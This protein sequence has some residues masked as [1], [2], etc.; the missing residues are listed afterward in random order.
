MEVIYPLWWCRWLQEQLVSNGK[1]VETEAAEMS[2]TSSLRSASKCLSTKLFSY[3]FCFR[4]EEEH[5]NALEMERLRNKKN[6]V[7]F[8]GDYFCLFKNYVLIQLL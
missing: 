7:V 8:Q 4:M 6:Y 3:F 5:F 1:L 2:I